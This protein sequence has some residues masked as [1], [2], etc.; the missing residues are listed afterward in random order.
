M[1]EEILVSSP[2]NDS[3]VFLSTSEAV[4]FGKAFFNGGG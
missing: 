1:A 4:G 3:E 2:Q